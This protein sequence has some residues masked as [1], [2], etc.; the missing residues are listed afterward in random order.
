MRLLKRNDRIK[1]ERDEYYVQ[2]G[3]MF[4]N[5]HGVAPAEIVRMI[6]DNTPEMVAQTVFGKYVEA[7]GLVFTAELIQ[8]IFDRSLPRI[9]GNGWI[10]ESA[11]VQ[12]EETRR[13]SGDGSLR[14]RF[15]TGADLARLRDYTVI[16]T[17]D[18]IRMP[19][20]VVYYR[21]IN[22]VPWESIY[23]EIGRARTI[24]GPSV[25]IDSTGMGGDVVLDALWE[26]RYCPMHHAANLIGH[27]CVEEDGTPKECKPEQYLSLSCVEGYDFS[28]VGQSSRKK[29]LVDH[30]RNI[31][32]VGYTTAGPEGEFGWLRSPPIPQLEEEL[33]FYSW[34]D[35]GLD[36]DC[37]FGLALAVWHGLE[38][39]VRDASIGSPFGV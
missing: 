18:T 10:D 21:R 31:L 29:Q 37:L 32:S 17:I 16:F 28:P 11:R 4:E 24:F 13:R 27:R 38:D 15:Y 22:R 1:L 33:S 19:A 8:R 35:K 5:P 30:L 20:K 9:I 2:T 23:A 25:L 36:T 39:P 34:D 3:S 6:L 12:A 14:S 7:S 26:R